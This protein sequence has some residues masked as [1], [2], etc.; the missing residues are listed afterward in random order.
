M[1]HISEVRLYFK[2]LQFQP[3][4]KPLPVLSFIY[5]FIYY[6]S[7]T[8]RHF[9]RIMIKYLVYRYIGALIK[10]RHV[11]HQLKWIK[12]S[13]LKACDVT[14]MPGLVDLCKCGHFLF[15]FYRE[16]HKTI[17]CGRRPSA[18]RQ[19]YRVGN[20]E[21][22]LWNDIGFSSSVFTRK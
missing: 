9:V 1:N 20:E 12:S 8:C 19:H 2:L 10:H 16:T 18:K 4:L 14:C 7:H 6:S 5:P 21:V 15:L 17:W 11:I 13:K 3:I 22:I